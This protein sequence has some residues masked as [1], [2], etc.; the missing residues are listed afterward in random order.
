MVKF[1]RYRIE[2]KTFYC[3]TIHRVASPDYDRDYSRNRDLFIR[4]FQICLVSREWKDLSIFV[5]KIKSKK[6]AIARKIL[7]FRFIDYFSIREIIDLII[8]YISYIYHIIVHFFIS[9]C[10]IIIVCAF[11][12]ELLSYLRSPNCV[13]FAKIFLIFCFLFFLLCNWQV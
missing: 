4:R 3:K 7:I 11:N 2:I 5:A 13:L 1:P 12:W 6:R 10:Y 8:Q 9:N